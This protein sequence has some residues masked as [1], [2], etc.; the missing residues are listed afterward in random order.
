VK[1][2]ISDP[3]PIVILDL[4]G[5]SALFHTTKEEAEARGQKFLFFTTSQDRATYY[6]NPFAAFQTGGVGIPEVTQSLL[7]AM[8][9]NHGE[10]YGRSYFTR[11]SR[12]RLMTVL[13]Q[14]GIPTSFHDLY[15]KIMDV[16]DHGKKYIDDAFE[17]HAAVESFL[18]YPQLFTTPEQERNY[19]ES[20]INFNRALEERHVVYFWLPA[21]TQSMAA[22]E[23]GKLAL[24]NI[25]QAAQ[26]R[27]DNYLPERQ[28]YL[29]MDEF[30]RLFGD[31]L[32]IILEQARS[33]GIGAVLS[34]H[35]A[36]QLRTDDGKDL[37][38][39]INGN[40]A[41]TLHFGSKDLAEL[42]MLSRL[43]GEIEETRES[44]SISRGSSESSNLQHGLT[45][46]SAL[47][48]T[49]S[50]S[51][52]YAPRFMMRD[53]LRIFS[54]KRRFI[55]SVQRNTGFSRFN[56]EPVVV[57]GIFTMSKETYQRRRKAKWPEGPR[58]VA[59]VLQS[60]K[61][62]FGQARPSK[63]MLEKIRVLTLER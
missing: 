32:R 54:Q 21:P 25:F 33:Y 53:L 22:K 49:V 55:L 58:L 40:T 61:A 2:L 48:N 57:D 1:T 23:I 51:S 52:G 10:G 12:Q 38:P 39:L 24:F 44:Y 59:G 8:G 56:G 19:P 43:S 17:L 50:Y 29:F 42:E 20:I 4:K 45:T 13:Q 27:H 3:H 9:L 47:T 15:Q 7:D 37:W 16:P 5:D 18:L 11:V 31:N 6:F 41:A 63:E 28:V 35:S 62:E 46:S 14:K 26:A 36:A 34:N 60:P 30:Q